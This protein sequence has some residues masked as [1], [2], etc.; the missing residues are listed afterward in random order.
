MSPGQPPALSPARPAALILAAG[1]S[2]RL[3]RPKQSVVFAG[4]SLL[5]R[6]IRAAQAAELHPILAVVNDSSWI[7][8]EPQG[9]VVLQNPDAH[10]GMS[11]SVGTGI[12]WLLQHPVPGAI[13][14]ACDQPGLHPDHLRALCADPTRITGSR[15][16]DRTGVPAYFPAHAFPQLLE[17]RGDAGARTLLQ[18]AAA[19][20]NEALAFDIDTEEDLQRAGERL[21]AGLL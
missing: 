11:T 2:R 16:A 10:E 5:E 17:L 21:P 13:L 4:L 9:I 20:P 6:T 1:F 18:H 12:R 15:Y 7:S 3:G 8:L 19:I 14:M